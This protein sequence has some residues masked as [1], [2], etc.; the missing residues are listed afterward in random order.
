MPVYLKPYF[1]SI[2]AAFLY[3]LPTK[4]S[5]Q[6]VTGP[7]GAQ[8]WMMGGA[9]AATADV[10]SA[11][12][13][14]A[15]MCLL[16]I[17]QLGLYTEQRFMEKNLKLANISGVLKTK[18]L[19]AGGYIH[20]FGYEA[21]NQQRLGFSLGKKLA[22]NISLGIQLNYLATNIREYGNSRAWV[23]GAGILYKPIPKLTTVITF[24]NI[25]QA[26]YNQTLTERIPATARLGV[27]YELSAKVL[28]TAETEQTLNQK[29]VFRGGLRYQLHEVIALAM[30]AANNPVY[31]T[32]GVG[33]KMKQL[34]LDMASGFHEV[35]GFTPH[36]SISFPL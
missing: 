10:W 20:Y 15:V 14:P 16:P 8:A 27:S 4:S 6:G 24:F 33:L 11:A 5:A 12:N 35:L 13:N 22:D 3:V 32:F 9:S 1:L 23:L 2:L 30:G 21:F 36:L 25:N 7:T 26:R 17:N 19:Y 29:T 31:Y 34:K 28:T 18:W